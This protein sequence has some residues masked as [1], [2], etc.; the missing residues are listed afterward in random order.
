MRRVSVGSWGSCF[1]IQLLAAGEFDPETVSEI[2]QFFGLS[3]NN[4]FIGCPGPSFKFKISEFGGVRIITSRAGHADKS[5]ELLM[6]KL[7]KPMTSMS[8]ED[9]EDPIGEVEATT[10]LFASIIPALTIDT[11]EL[12]MPS[13]HFSSTPAAETPVPTAHHCNV[14]E[15]LTAKQLR[16]DI[17]PVFHK[18]D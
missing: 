11:V 8:P 13:R 3:K 1:W 15:Q 7:E 5:R 12:E 2:A 10:E 4:V 18:T 16:A 9:D 14:S 17:E 6:T